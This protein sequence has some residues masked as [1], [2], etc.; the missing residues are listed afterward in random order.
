MRGL[1]MKEGGGIGG[2]RVVKEGTSFQSFM[3][4]K[5]REIEPQSLGE[6]LQIMYRTLFE[7]H[8]RCGTIPERQQLRGSIQRSRRRAFVGPAHLFLCT[9]SGRVPPPR[10]HAGFQR[11]QVLINIT[12]RGRDYNGGETI[13]E[14]RSGAIIELGECF[15]QGD[16]FSFP[17]EYFHQGQAR[18]PAAMRGSIGRISVLMPYHRLSDNAIRY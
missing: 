1:P 11:T 8:V 10:P 17:Y 2:T 3:F 7:A 4:R 18:C 5:V 9:W 12:K 13:I 15:D 6:T 14:D 16:M